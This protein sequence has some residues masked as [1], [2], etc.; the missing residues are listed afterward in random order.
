LTQ[1]HKHKIIRRQLLVLHVQ[2]TKQEYAG[3]HS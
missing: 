3:Q 1:P 2:S